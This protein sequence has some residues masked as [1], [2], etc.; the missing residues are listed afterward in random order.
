MAFRR[1][2]ALAAASLLA[3][4][5]PVLA[6][7]DGDPQRGR[8]LTYTCYGCHGIPNYKN[9]YPTYSVPKLQGQHPEYLAAALTGYRNGDRA[10]A[11][12]H[13]QASTMSD[14][15]MQDIAAFLAGKPLAAPPDAKP[16]GEMPKKAQELCASCHGPTGISAVAIYPNLAGQHADYIQRALLDYKSGARKNAI[17]SG[18]VADLTPDQIR[19]LAQFFSEQRPSLDTAEHAHWFAEEKKD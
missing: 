6:H 19:E 4:L 8:K 1:G 2:P 10:H 5:L 7:A 15:D 14:Q 16:K 12:M 11:T 18:F 17:M 3:F 9:V 13:A